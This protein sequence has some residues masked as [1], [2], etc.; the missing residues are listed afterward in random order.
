MVW[1]PFMVSL[2]WIG[3]TLRIPRTD[4]LIP[5]FHRGVARLFNLRISPQG[6]PSIDQ[7]TLYVSN[8]VSYMDVFVLGANLPGSFVAK[9]EVAGWPVFGKLAKLQHTL[10]F[11]RKTHRAAQQVKQ[12]QAHLRDN[13]NLILFPEGTSTPGTHI[14]PFRSSLFEAAADP[15]IL[16]QPVTVAYSHYER[17]PMTQT[18]RDYYAWYIPMPFLSHFLNGLGLGQVD[19]QIIYHPW[20]RL[21]D[22]ASRKACALHCENAVR[23]GLL[24]ALG[25]AEEFRPA[26]YLAAVR[27]QHVTTV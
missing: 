3:K 10:F 19:V 17:Q 24:Q 6:E 8:H 5:I 23:G 21:A 2:L 22:F 7:R 26:R 4:R 27:R 9:S 18:I 13:G 14:E 16:I 20:V 25:T 12:M 1:I 15:E 11:E